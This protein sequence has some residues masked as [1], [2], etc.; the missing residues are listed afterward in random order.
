MRAPRVARS[1]P[2]PRRPRRPSAASSGIDPRPQ[3][4]AHLGDGQLID[5][6]LDP[7]QDVGEPGPDS[8]PRTVH[9]PRLNPD[10]DDGVC[11][12]GCILQIDKDRLEAPLGSQ[13]AQQLPN[14]ARLAHPSLRG[15]QRMRSVLN[16]RSKNAKLTVPVEKAIP[17]D[18]VRPRLLQSGRYFPNRFVAINNACKQFCCQAQGRTRSS[19]LGRDGVRGYAAPRRPV[20]CRGHRWSSPRTERVDRR[21]PDSQ[22]P[23]QLR[24]RGAESKRG[25]TGAVAAI[26]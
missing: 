18:P 8:V 19:S 6:I 9:V 7:A 5:S 22:P 11:R 10:F 1:S 2:G 12:G 21:C 16:S 23:L 15:Q 17:I 25:G 20:G 4:H 24:T 13:T 3:L 26:G 14:Q